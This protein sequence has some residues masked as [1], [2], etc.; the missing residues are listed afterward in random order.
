MS[1]NSEMTSLAD[2]IRAKSGVSGKLTITGMTDAV[3][4]IEI[5]QGS[6]ID[7]SGVNVTA[8]KMLSGVVAINAAGSKVTGNI[9]TV[10]ATK[11]SNK[12]TVPAGHIASQQIVTVGTAKS[13][14]TIT[15]ST[16]DQT[17]AADTYLSGKQTIKGDANLTAE[18]IKSG[19]SIFNVAGTFEGAGGTGGSGTFDLAKVTE[20]SA[21]PFVL[22]GVL[23]TGY[24]DGEWSF[25]TAEK[26][27]AGFE[28]TPKAGFIY[29]AAG[30]MLVGGSI[31]CPYPILLMPLNGNLTATSYGA[32]ITP[33]VNGT[34][35]FDSHG[36][37][38]TGNQYIDLPIDVGFF[39]KNATIC[40]K[41][42]QTGSGRYGYVAGTEDC[43]LGI[44]SNG[45]VFSLWA[46]QGGS[47]NIFD[48]D[49][50]DG[51][52]DVEIPRNTEVHIAYIHNADTGTYQLAID[53]DIVKEISETRSIAGGVNL[54]FGAWGNGDYRFVGSMRDIQV[55]D[56]ALSAEE[57]ATIANS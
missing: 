36:A 12:V 32:A 50:W 1:F 41:M 38:F 9:Q 52:S 8:D 53:G 43:Y 28:E 22:K 15:P 3:E 21:S 33:Q 24:A 13:A 34:L 54:R 45:G 14:A 16:S 5:N 23:A 40:F 6:D 47:W 57:L 37:K 55:Y 42:Y 26:S 56:K 20:Y 2:A 48:S 49:G 19:V 30:D 35:T 4:G 51:R 25:D 10:T 31:G 7:F 11:S 46:G 18:N 39:A 17:I 44:D 29:A 27:F